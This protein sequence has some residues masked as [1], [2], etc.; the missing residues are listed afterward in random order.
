LNHVISTHRTRNVNKVDMFDWNVFGGS[1]LAVPLH[2]YK[3]EVWTHAQAIANKPH[4][5]RWITTHE[6]RIIARVNL[7][8]GPWT[9]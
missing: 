2:I 9:V 8:A 3:G 5:I 7:I 4:V 6:I 1:Q